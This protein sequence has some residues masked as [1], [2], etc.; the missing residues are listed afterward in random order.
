[1]PTTYAQ[2][3]KNMQKNAAFQNYTLIECAAYSE[4]SVLRFQDYGLVFSSLN[5]A[6]GV[7]R[8]DS[9]IEQGQEVEVQASRFD[10]IAANQ[11]LEKIDL[12]KIDA[13]SSEMHV[14]RG[15]EGVLSQFKPK[16]N[17]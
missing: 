7:R 17:Y 15:M 1:M 3:N 9:S 6:F 8:T 11:N 5:S 10:E 13:E 14:L 16:V 2:L 12:I 4:S